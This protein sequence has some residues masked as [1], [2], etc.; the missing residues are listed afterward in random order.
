ME[1]GEKHGL[2][3]PEQFGSRKSLS[4]IEHALNKHLVLDILQQTHVN[5]IYIA[6]DAKACYDRIILMVAYLTMRNFG[7]PA[8]VAKATI[9]SILGMQHKVLTSYGDSETYY[10]GDKWKTKPHSCG[11]GN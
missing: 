7:V 6:N 4:A 2:L 1:Y 8:L 10:G 5:V 3:A 11:Q 9:S